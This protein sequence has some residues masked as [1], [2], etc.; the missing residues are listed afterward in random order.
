MLSKK[1]RREEPFIFDA[2]ISYCKEDE[3]WIEVILSRSNITLIPE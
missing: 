3:E 1:V 2:F